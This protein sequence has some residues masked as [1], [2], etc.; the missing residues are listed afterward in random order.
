MPLFCRPLCALLAALLAAST[1]RAQ[2][3]A[4]VLL[5][6]NG[7]TVAI[8]R[9]TR[10]ATS[11]EAELLVPTGGARFWYQATLAPDAS[12]AR[13]VNEFRPASAGRDAE[14]TQRAVF[15][16]TGDS[17]IVEI[18][19]GGRSVTQRLGSRPGAVPFLNP[20][21]ALVEQIVRRARR[22][23]GDS[24]AVPAFMVQGGTVVPFVVRRLPG[25]SVDVAVGGVPSRLAVNAAGD[26][27]GGSVPAQGLR[28]VRVS[29]LPAGAMRV[30]PRSY[31]A[32]P[33]APYTAEEVRVPTSRGYALAGTLTMPRNAAGL[34]PAVVTITGSGLQ[35]RDESIPAVRGYAL[36]RQI[37]DTLSR[38]GVAVLRMDDR[39][40]G[41]SGG[42]ASTATLIDLADDIRSGMAWLRQRPGIDASRLVLVGHSEGGIIAPMIAAT[43][44]ALAGIVLM[45]APAWSG[46]RVIESQNRYLLERAPNLSAAEQDSLL[47]ASMRTVDS[48]AVS[49][50]WLRFFLAY[51]PLATA[52]RVKVP[53]L[54]LHGATDRQ[55]TAEQAEALA[56]AF[57]EG[58]NGDV[59]VRVFEQTNHLFLAD[60][61]GNWADYPKL[62]EHAVR[63]AILG[64]LVA[65]VV[66]HAR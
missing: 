57:R 35:E 39:G 43:D 46:R 58:G 1:A 17:A 53:V 11:L 15:T 8:E 10:N 28:I 36:F 63:P 12:V 7:D 47:E 2:G 49:S 24:V 18:T 5:T 29:A 20:S 41:E 44:T 4:F 26:V 61:V 6:A 27:T 64:T 62:T 54:I 48:A 19:G 23:G 60:S 22:I 40:A 31:A 34:V 56:R 32:P 21:F 37:A 55:V 3:D 42:D 38:R 50:P 59:T 25:D 51:D 16:F 30:E 13:F 66:A 14:P 52:R 33:G 65:W 45:A 9:F